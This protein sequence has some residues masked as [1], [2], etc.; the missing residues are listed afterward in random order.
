[1]SDGETLPLPPDEYMRLVCGPY[2]GQQLHDLFEWVG[3]QMVKSLAQLGVI[4]MGYQFLDIGCGC[5]RVARHLLNQSL[6]AYVGFDRHREMIEWCHKEIASRS[7]NF[8]FLHF[9]SHRYSPT[10]RWSKSANILEK[11]T[12]L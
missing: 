5:G 4:G 8:R 2:E 3:D 1:M 11:Y 9:S 7:D 6:K 10:G 12:G